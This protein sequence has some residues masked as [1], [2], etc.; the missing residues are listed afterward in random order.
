MRD[1]Y[2][3]RSFLEAVRERVSDLNDYMF[4]DYLNKALSNLRLPPQQKPDEEFVAEFTGSKHSITLPAVLSASKVETTIYPDSDKEVSSTE[5]EQFLEEHV[6]QAR[7]ARYECKRNLED[8]SF[9]TLHDDYNTRIVTT[10]KIKQLHPAL[11]FVKSMMTRNPPFCERG[12]DG[13]IKPTEQGLPRPDLHPVQDQIIIVHFTSH[14]RYLKKLNIG[15]ICYVT[16]RQIHCHTDLYSKSWMFSLERELRPGT[17][18]N[19]FSHLRDIACETNE[20]QFEAVDNVFYGDREFPIRKCRE[21]KSKKEFFLPVATSRF[22]KGY[23][24][25]DGMYIT[26]GP[27]IQ[28]NKQQYLVPSSHQARVFIRANE[29]TSMLRDGGGGFSTFSFDTSGGEHVCLP[30]GTKLRLVKKETT[31]IP[32]IGQYNFFVGTNYLFD[33]IEN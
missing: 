22:E 23:Q 31:N 28:M 33:L 16:E 1:K 14:I 11:Q 18:T 4:D 20:A 6:S 5:Q 3:S 13:V 2:R 8:A 24:L 9:T 30:I 12:M 21:Q 10:Y 7:Q 19:N 26:V 27:I 25:N 32:V 29:K 17:A 15:D